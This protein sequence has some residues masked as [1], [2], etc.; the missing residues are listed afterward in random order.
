MLL[1]GNGRLI[2]RGT[3]N[4]LIEN[5]CV[6]I[7]GNLIREVGETAPLRARYPKAQWID[8]T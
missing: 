8:L 6:A 2:T 5:G 1:V 7:E 3:P 4:R